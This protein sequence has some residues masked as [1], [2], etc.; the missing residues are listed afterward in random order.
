MPQDHPDKPQLLALL[1]SSSSSSTS[2]QQKKQK[3]TD[4]KGG[5]AAV[6]ASEACGPPQVQAFKVKATKTYGNEVAYPA[7]EDPP[8]F[9]V[10]LIRNDQCNTHVHGVAQNA[11]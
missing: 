2:D 11:Q 9:N 7:Q 10:T 1:K 4:S 3:A 5:S 8:M 6:K